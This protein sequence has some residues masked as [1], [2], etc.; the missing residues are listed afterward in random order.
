MPE[1]IKYAV[2][3]DGKNFTDIGTAKNIWAGMGVKEDLKTFVLT[4]SSNTNARYIKMNFK[5][6]SSA[7]STGDASS[8]S[9]LCDEIIVQ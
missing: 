9:M 3:N 7:N 4:P 8:Q 2:S 5:M 1:Y 6:V